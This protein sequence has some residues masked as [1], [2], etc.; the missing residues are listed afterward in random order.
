MLS[1]AM[2][3]V[4]SSEDRALRCGLYATLAI[5]T[6]CSAGTAPEIWSVCRGDANT[7]RKLSPSDRRR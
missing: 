7:S 4:A 5:L 6:A 2:C 1:D 3:A